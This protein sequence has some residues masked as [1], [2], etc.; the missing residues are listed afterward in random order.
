MK[1]KKQIL[2]T[3]DYEPFLGSSSGTAQNCVIKPTNALLDILEKYRA[4]AIFFV[5]TLYLENLKK[6]DVNAFDLIVNQLQV[7]YSKKH[8]IFPHIHPHWLDAVFEEKT[9]TFSLKNITRYSLSS[10]TDED[11]H[12]LF[13]ESIDFL[14]QIGISY[15]VWGYRAGGWCIQPFSL[16]KMAFKEQ[17]INYDFSV[18]PGYQNEHPN[19]KFDFSNV[20]MHTPY[21]F[22]DDVTINGS[23]G[24]FVE[25][26]I[27]TISYGAPTLLADK[28]VRKYLWKTND[29]GYGDGTSAQTKGLRSV[30]PDKEMISIDVLTISKLNGCKKFL[31]ENDYMHWISHPKMFTKHGLRTFDKFLNYAESNYTI[32]YNLKKQ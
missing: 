17:H 18:L 20:K 26:P 12:R 2:L 10:L 19:Q 32:E 7:A 29:R 6:H 23:N 4:Q 31:K 1:V 14:K 15:D 28:F 21:F 27:S 8:V 30:S 9:R 3:F 11:I 25:F 16:F 24:N 5:D 13:K 22:E